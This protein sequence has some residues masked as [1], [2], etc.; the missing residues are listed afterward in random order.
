[1][2]CKE[3]EELAT[4]TQL[5]EDTVLALTDQNDELW[6]NYKLGK[7]MALALSRDKMYFAK[8]RAFNKLMDEMA[9]R[10]Q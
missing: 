1:M 5:D 8:V 4:I 3:Q 10:K 6:N 2:A 7:R 9:A